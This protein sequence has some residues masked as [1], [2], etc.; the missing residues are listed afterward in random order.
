MILFQ[1]LKLIKKILVLIIVLVSVRKEVMSIKIDNFASNN[2]KGIC[3]SDKILM[4]FEYQKNNIRHNGSSPRNTLI[5][6]R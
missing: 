4:I 6:A 5:N 3:S 2:D 1:I